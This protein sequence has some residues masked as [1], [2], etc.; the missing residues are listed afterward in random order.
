MNHWKMTCSWIILLADMKILKSS[1][2]CGVLI[3]SMKKKI[4]FMKYSITILH[5]S[6]KLNHTLDCHRNLKFPFFWKKIIRTSRWNHHF[7][8]SLI[9]C[10]HFSMWWGLSWTSDG[11]H[12]W[13]WG[14][15]RQ[16]WHLIISPVAMEISEWCRGRVSANE[17]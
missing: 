8:D 9:Y 10:F 7:I 3:I 13:V 2:S 4:C 5:Q 17:G 6:Y 14:E 16:L 15:T 11:R 1:L 12:W